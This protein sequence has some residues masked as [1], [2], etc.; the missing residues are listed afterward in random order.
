[1]ETGELIFITGGVRS[2]KSSFAE[3]YATLCAQLNGNLQYIATS[4]A[5]DGEMAQRIKSHQKQREQSG[6]AWNTWEC[7]VDLHTIAPYFNQSDI[8]LLDCLTVLLSNEFFRDDES[9]QTDIYNKILTGIDAILKQVQTLI[10]VSNE[11][12]NEP[13]SSESLTQSYASLLGRLHQHIVQRSSKTYLVEAGIPI[14]MK[15]QSV[16]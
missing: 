11:V 16:L 2:G 9:N 6:E 7:P 5:T 4:T 1:M 3:V 10:I 13:L 12:L 14:L 15:E 8:V